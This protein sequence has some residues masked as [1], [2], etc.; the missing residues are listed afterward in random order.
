MR[1]RHTC[2]M[3]SRSTDRV[4]SW[5]D[6]AGCGSGRVLSWRVLS[7]RDPALTA[8]WLGVVLQD[9]IHAHVRHVRGALAAGFLG[10]IDGQTSCRMRFMHTCGMFDFSL[11]DMYKPETKRLNKVFSALLLLLLLLCYSPA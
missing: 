3:F 7:W 5:R 1:F 8:C 10:V 2:G 11:K 4:L 6:P 9:A